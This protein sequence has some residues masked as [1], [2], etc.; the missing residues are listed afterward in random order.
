MT[1]QDPG[2]PDS[3]NFRWRTLRD[4]LAFQAKLLMDG[5]RDL[6][7]SPVSLVAA[8]ID[9][10]N[11]SRDGYFPRV[12]DWGRKTER[13]INLFGH[14]DRHH[15]DDDENRQRSANPKNMDEIVSRLEGLVVE[16]YHKGG[17]TAAAKRAIDQG[18]DRAASAGS[19]R[20]AAKTEKTEPESGQD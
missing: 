8:L 2:N 1:T 11:P 12:I 5:L 17:M 6:V 16:Q 15:A 9:I 18:L 13:W 19:R 14:Y 10:I 4:M 20:R 3:R 7:I